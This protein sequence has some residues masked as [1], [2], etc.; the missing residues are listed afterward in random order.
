MGAEPRLRLPRRPRARSYPAL[1]GIRAVAVAAVL[2]YHFGVGAARGGFLGVDVF[3]VLSGYLITG[4]LVTRWVLAGDV[5]LVAFWAARARRLLPALGAVLIGTT[6][7]V[8]LVDRTQLSLFRG[9]VAAAATYSSNWWYVFH[10]RSYF[11]AVGRPPL[12]QHLW[13][14]AVEEQFYAVWPLVIAAV[15]AGCASHRARLR[16]LLGVAAGIGLASSVLMAVGTALSHSPEAGDPSRWYFGS[17][18]HVMGLMAGAALALVRRG[19]GLGA[20]PRPTPRRVSSPTRTWLGAAALG[21]LLLALSRTDEYAMWLYR[22][23]FLAVSLLTVVVIAIATRPGPLETLLSRPILRGL[24]RRSYALYLWHWPVACLTRPGIDLPI[25]TAGAFALRLG[26]TLLLAEMSY[27]WI[28]QPVRRHGWRSVWRVVSQ[29]RV[30]RFRAPT[31]ITVALGALA[32]GVILPASAVPTEPT[33]AAGGT[34]YVSRPGRPGTVHVSHTTPGSGHSST[35]PDGSRGAG[36]SPGSSGRGGPGGPDGPGQPD[37]AS[38]HDGATGSARDGDHSPPPHRA[39]TPPPRSLAELRRTDLVVYGDSVPLGAI[40]DLAAAFRS[41]TNNAS[42]GAQ[43]WSLLPELTSDARAGRLDGDVVLLHTG[44]N[45]VISRTQLEA[46]LSALAGAARVV[47]AMPSVPRPWQ[48]GNRS[49]IAA[50]VAEHPN[51]V[52]LD[53]AATARSHPDFLWSDGIHL[54]ASGERG[55][56][57]RVALA[58]IHD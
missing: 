42:V 41:V 58:A 24:G 26:L 10:E 30:G 4:Q 36:S 9:D 20:V 19:D 50:V 32:T 57:F 29:S 38:G 25:S 23:G 39:A 47:V 45:G 31:V 2:L 7:A 13:S 1:D 22:W 37:R 28:E 33:L 18:S 6:T 5:S 17:D 11:A 49:I 52:L 35:T 40:P 56:A 14:L 55:Y 21:L 8:I 48:E 53:W 12:L 46:A 51:V 16:I 44:D 15:V 27:Q 43:A 34:V 3:F 54:T